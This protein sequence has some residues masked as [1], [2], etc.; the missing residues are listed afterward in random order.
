VAQRLRID[1]AIEADI[2]RILEISNWAAVNTTHH[3][4]TQPE[5]LQ[6]WLETW[7]R[8][9]AMYPWLV[10]RREG[11]IIGWAK[12]G[13]HNARQAYAWTA[14]LS[15]YVAPESHGQ[16]AGTALY[17]A[18]I[19]I[20][21]AQGYVTLIAG[22]TAGNKASE[23]LHKKAGFK[24]CATYHRAGWKS[25]AWHDVNYYEMHLQPEGQAPQAVRPVASVRTRLESVE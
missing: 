7:R 6:Q 18:L 22:V 2:P 21:R 13:P 25:G 9:Q 24:Q 12:A 20:L 14:D 15:V 5:P 23:R 10:A 4:A 19:P 8:T 1:L 17:S 3:F 11:A 16:G